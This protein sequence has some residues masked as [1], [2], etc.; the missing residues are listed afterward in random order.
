MFKAC[1][2]AVEELLKGSGR[3]STVLPVFIRK[4]TL[5]MDNL[6]LI[7]NLSKI[8]SHSSTQLKILSSPLFEQVL[9][10]VS[11]APITMKKR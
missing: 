4:R 9:Y 11:T 5:A 10:P 7:R 1:V 6:A 8:H 3:L 2:N